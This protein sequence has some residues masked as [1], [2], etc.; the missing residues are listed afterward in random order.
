MPGMERTNK[1]E[2]AR[3]QN[4]EQGYCFNSIIFAQVVNINHGMRP[5]VILLDIRQ[6]N[7]IL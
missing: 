7:T 4:E 3:Q 5:L 6:S 1:A 2:H